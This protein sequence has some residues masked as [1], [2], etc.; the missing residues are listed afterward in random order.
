[1]DDAQSAFFFSRRYYGL[2]PLVETNCDD[3]RLIHI[4][5]VEWPSFAEPLILIFLYYVLWFESGSLLN[6]VV[7]VN[8]GYSLWYM[9]VNSEF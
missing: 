3:P 2:T 6:L 8:A 1:V 7:S 9:T 4:S 5:D